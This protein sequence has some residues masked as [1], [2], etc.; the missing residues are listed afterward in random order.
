MLFRCSAEEFFSEFQ[1]DKQMYTQFLKWMLILIFGTIS[2][3][4]STQADPLPSWNNGKTKSAI[5]AFVTD[6]TNPTSP[7]FVPVPERI[8][9]FDN[10]G[11]LWSEQPM[12]FQA[13]FALARIKAMAKDHPEWKTT[14][15]YKSALSG[16]M[17]GMM[18]GG[19]APLEKMLVEA[20]ANI[21]GDAFKQAVLQWQETARHPKT[22]MPFIGMV[23]QPML[24]LLT[25]LRTN[26]FKTY[27]VS[28]GG[29]DFM[30][31]FSE[32]VYG[33][34]PEQV[35]GTTIDAKFEMVDGVPTITKTPKLMHFDD[36]AGKPVGIY[37]YIG[38]KPIFAAGNSDGDLQMLQ[39]TTI[40]ADGKRAVG[41][42]GLIVHHTDADGE[43]AYDRK[44][45]FGKLDKALDAAPAQGWTVIDM[46]NDWKRIYPSAK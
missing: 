4:A 16:D 23:F 37:Q 3:T 30:R 41:K 26:N 27:I 38:R 32:K 31:A 24:E 18:A 35:V 19:K 21:T 25:Y 20:H 10:D 34:P 33:I 8:A 40:G 17:K 28:G 5:I 45:A 13:F 9:T 7:H 43:F 36:K 46:K 44:A 22:G 15:P 29:T 1:Q 14:E 2:A 11:T 12:Y 39:Y 6:V 42:F